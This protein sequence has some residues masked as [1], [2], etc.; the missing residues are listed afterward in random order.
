MSHPD[1]KIYNQ[2]EEYTEHYDLTY[3]DVRQ[4]TS[5]K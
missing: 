1:D 3:Q 5:S 2:C 4:D